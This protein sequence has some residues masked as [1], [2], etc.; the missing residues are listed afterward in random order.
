ML[1]RHKCLLV[2][3]EVKE[4]ETTKEEEKTHN[5]VEETTLQ[6]QVEGET[7][8][9]KVKAQARVKHKDKGMINPKS[10]VIIVK[11]MGIMP[12]NVERNKMKWVIDLM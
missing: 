1:S 5:E 10:N 2:D 11:S 9:I 4:D 7:T 8:K 3:V 6:A 12:M